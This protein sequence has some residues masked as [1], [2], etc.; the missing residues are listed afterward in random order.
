MFCHVFG[1]NTPKDIH[2]MTATVL[3][4][5]SLADS[6][7]LSDVERESYQRN[8]HVLLRGL[9]SADAVAAYRTAINEA[10]DRYNTETRALSDRDTY[11]KAFLQIF[12]L[13]ERDE[14]VR[15]F[16]LAK[17]FGEVAAQLMG[18]E[19]VR[20]YH[21]QA[22]YKEPGG[23]P[24][25]WHQ[26]QY[27]WP[28]DTNQFVT[29]WMPLIDLTADMGIMQFASGSH[30]DGYVDK[31]GISDASENF[32]EHYVRDRNFPI[33]QAHAMQAGDATFHAGW[34]LHRAPGNTSTTM[35]EVMTVIYFADGARVIEPDN[36]GR[37]ADL[38]RW[39]PGLKPGD[40]AESRLNPVV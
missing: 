16:T 28:L 20:I 35:R 26:D 29:M 27:Y 5:L 7:P 10:V 32:L 23:G 22:L 13:W 36:K 34:T 17:R 9:A 1:R 33:A 14:T 12:N 15:R 8:G 24:T 37:V 38:G 25:P 39:L 4:S 2:D 11:G 40:R 21:D 31:L 19:R 18:C 3:P 30:R 6:F